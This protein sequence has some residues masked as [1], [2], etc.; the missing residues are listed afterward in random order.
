VSVSSPSNVLEVNVGATL[1]NL[2]TL[3]NGG[4]LNNSG[5]LNEGASIL[6]VTNDG[7][8]INNAGGAITASQIQFTLGAATLLNGG[9]VNANIT[10]GN[11]AN[12]VQLSTGSS[13]V[14][15]LNL[16]TNAGTNLMLDGSGTALLS[17]A[18]TG[19]LTNAGSLVKQGIGTWTDVRWSQPLRRR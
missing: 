13:I 5:T 3:S 8:V 4:I 17:Q 11:F 14:G 9:T 16:G 6:S 19:T 7:T 10:F 1:A 2:V 18:V 15:N 12:T